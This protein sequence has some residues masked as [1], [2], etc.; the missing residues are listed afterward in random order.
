[1]LAFFMVLVLTV[2]GLLAWR[3]APSRPAAAVE[4]CVQGVV[5]VRAVRRK[6]SRDAVVRR[7][8]F[9]ASRAPGPLCERT[10]GFHTHRADGQVLGLARIVMRAFASARFSPARC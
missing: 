6:I 1:M 4:T 10:S 5:R 2:G 9:Y 3:A 7:S 8:P